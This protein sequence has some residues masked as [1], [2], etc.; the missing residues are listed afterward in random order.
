[1]TSQLPIHC[2][3]QTV[4]QIK[5]F[6]YYF[7]CPITWTAC[8]A[9]QQWTSQRNY[10]PLAQHVHL[11]KD[12]DPPLFLSYDWLPFQKSCGLGRWL[13]P[14]LNLEQFPLKCRSNGGAQ[15]QPP[16]EINCAFNWDRLY[17]VLGYINPGKTQL[18]LLK[19]APKVWFAT[20]ELCAI[21]KITL[22]TIVWCHKEN[23]T[24]KREGR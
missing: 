13:S 21:Y 5:A 22:Y 3:L 6:V 9:P 24:G 4:G 11:H 20:Q 8:S 16:P 7:F 10:R 1:M 17:E 15:W 19:C 12:P 2:P 18:T 23:G 14:A